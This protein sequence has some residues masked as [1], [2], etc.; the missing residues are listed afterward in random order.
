MRLGSKT[1]VEVGGRGVSVAVGVGVSVAVG[2][3]V[4]R[5]GW[6]GVRVGVASSGT[7][8]RRKA[9][10]VRVGK[11]MTELEVVLVEAGRISPRLPNGTVQPAKKVVRITNKTIRLTAS[12]LLVEAIAG[13]Q[14]DRGAGNK[15][16]CSGQSRATPGQ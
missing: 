2:V 9:A 7:V 1:G 10:G 3:A 16:R 6:K 5:R 13:Q 4:G 15:S 12:L 14:L 8:A 11:S